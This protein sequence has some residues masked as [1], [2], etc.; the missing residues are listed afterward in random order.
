MDILSINNKGT[1]PAIKEIA[2]SIEEQGQYPSFQKRMTVL[3]ILRREK[4]KMFMKS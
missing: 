4:L 2:G 3:K 1:S